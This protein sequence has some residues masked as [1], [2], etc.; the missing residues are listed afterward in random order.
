MRGLGQDKSFNLTLSVERLFPLKA[1]LFNISKWERSLGSPKIAHT[2][3]T[4]EL[5]IAKLQKGLPLFITGMKAA[6][7]REPCNLLFDL[8]SDLFYKNKQ[9]FFIPVTFIAS[10]IDKTSLNDTI[11][12]RIFFFGQ[13]NAQP[14]EILSSMWR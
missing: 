2:Q 13:L 6:P 8:Q 4:E 12:N 7:Q 3:G 9:Q 11:N 5:P 10:V 14:E 1:K